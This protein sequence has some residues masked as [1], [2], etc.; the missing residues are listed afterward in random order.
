MNTLAQN[1]KSTEMMVDI[2]VQNQ[3]HL[4]QILAVLEG[5]SEIILVK[6][7]SGK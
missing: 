7:E 2:Q 1:D 5:Q 6:K 4:E 3:R